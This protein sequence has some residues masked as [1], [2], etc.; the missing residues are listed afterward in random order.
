MTWHKKIQKLLESMRTFVKLLKTIFYKTWMKKHFAML[1]LQMGSW[2]DL[3]KEQSKIN[4]KQNIPRVKLKTL[5]HSRH[6]S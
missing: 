4:P 6:E 3:N 2:L 1:F 5:N